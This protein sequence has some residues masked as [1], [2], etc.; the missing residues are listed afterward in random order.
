MTICALSIIVL[1]VGFMVRNTNVCRRY[2]PALFGKKKHRSRGVGRLEFRPETRFNVTENPLENLENGQM[3]WKSESRLPGVHRTFGAGTSSLA[4]Q[5]TPADEQFDAETRSFDGLFEDEDTDAAGAFPE[6]D[7]E[8]VD[9]FE[10][11]E[12]AIVHAGG[13]PRAVPEVVDEEEAEEGEEEDEASD[14]E[15]AQSYGGVGPSHL[16]FI[17]LPKSRSSFQRTTDTEGEQV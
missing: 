10:E 16:E 3:N 14:Q 6:A 9:D 5:Q 11:S 7:L 17:T 8:E 1:V 13:V 4:N 2:R 12:A 15:G